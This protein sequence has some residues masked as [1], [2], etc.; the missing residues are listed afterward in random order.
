MI[1]L[2]RR[3]VRPHLK[4]LQ[5]ANRAWNLDIGHFSDG[6]V[7]EYNKEIILIPVDQAFNMNTLVGAKAI[8][9]DTAKQAGRI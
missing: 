2:L 4:H 9:Y 1:G 7:I 8:C 3:S 5:L 6:Q